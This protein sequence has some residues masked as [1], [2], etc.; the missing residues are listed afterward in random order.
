MPRAETAGYFNHN[1]RWNAPLPGLASGS[2]KHPFV[3][4][5]VLVC[6]GA[7]TRTRIRTLSSPS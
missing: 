2:V 7:Q 6:S 3:R 4:V 5:S 1:A